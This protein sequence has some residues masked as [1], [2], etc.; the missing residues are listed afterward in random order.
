MTRRKN[1]TIQRLNNNKYLLMMLLPVLLYFVIFSYV[2]MYGVVIAFQDYL[3]GRSFF[4]SPWVGFKHFRD[5]FESMY[6]LRTLKN[7]VLLSIYS[8]IWGFWVPIAFALFLNELKDGRIK[9]FIQTV[10]YLPHFISLVVVIGM[11]K[12]FLDPSNGVINVLI[13]AFGGERID[14]FSSSEWFRTLYIA[15]GI[16]QSFGWSSII[17]LAALSGVDPTLYESADIDGASRL[18]KMFYITLPSLMP[19][20]ILLLILSLGSLMGVG[21]E[22]VILM[23]NPVVY[24][25]SDIISTYTYRKGILEANYSY[26]TAMGL[27]NSVISMALLVFFN[28]L[29]RRT[30][31]QS[32]W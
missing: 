7:T 17:Y 15:S 8:L 27:F 4:N 6:F 24:D 20:T 18:Q 19:V 16:W 12:M 32:I 22:K 31:Q 5:F 10:S 26:G 9:R 11:M 13:G 2:P 23:Y 14:F 1:R 30:T 21:F 29:S 25:V 3:P 28:R